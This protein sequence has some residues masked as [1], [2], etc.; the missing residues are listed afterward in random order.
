MG[1]LEN[2]FKWC[3]ERGEK[4]EKHKGLRKIEPDI[5]ESE[6]QIKKSLSDLNT[7]NYLYKGKRTDWVAS[8]AFYSMYHSL[9]ALLFKLGYESRN[10][11]CTITAVEN[12]MK[13][14][15]IDLEKEYLNMIRILKNNGEGAKS[16]REEMQ[17]SSET[18]MED[19]KCKELM[20]N[21]KKFVE[22]IREI[23]ESINEEEPEKE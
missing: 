14:G 17:Y 4:G 1:K 21:A 20:G 5:K 11:E 12:F 19:D 15:N 16:I 3:L 13:D 9:L 18:S 10:Q 7:M 23:I 22:R 6:N 2:R 8:A